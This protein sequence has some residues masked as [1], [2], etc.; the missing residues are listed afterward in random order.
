VKR[1]AVLGCGVAVS[2]LAT[3]AMAAGGDAAHDHSTGAHA[4]S[5]GLLTV[6]GMAM[7]WSIVVFILLL[8]ILRVV[9]WKPI[10]QAL[11]QRERFIADS[12][13][14]A[15]KEREEAERLLRQYTEQVHRA[16]EEATAIVEE[17]KRDAEAVRK[18][19]HEET[20]AEAHALM[21]RAKRD[22]AIARDDAIKSLYQQSVELASRMAGKLV[23]RELSP[24]DQG[25][26]LD[27]ALTELE[28]MRR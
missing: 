25:A 19:I 15:R 14:Q 12:L 17:G 3:A 23:G 1:L 13:A 8:L 22:L 20:R 16:R 9:A 5:Y 4:P 6:D 21:E 11:I 26:L 24:Q 7:V 18:R 28:Q 27:E 2:C 10:Q